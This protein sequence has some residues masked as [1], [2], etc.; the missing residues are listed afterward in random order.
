MQQLIVIA[1]SQLEKSGRGKDYW[2]SAIADAAFKTSD[3]L[4]STLQETP[5]ERLAGKNS[6]MT[7]IGCGVAIAM[8]T[9]IYSG[10][11]QVRNSTQNEVCL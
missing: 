9:N 8:F 1:R 11:G 6:I 4:T 10:E 7:D 3:M 5:C 2:M